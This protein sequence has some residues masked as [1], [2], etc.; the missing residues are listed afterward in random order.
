MQSFARLAAAEQDLAATEAQMPSEPGDAA[1]PAQHKLLAAQAQV[2]E[3]ANQ[4]KEASRQLQ[5]VLADK[6]RLEKQLVELQKQL[7]EQAAAHA[8][9]AGVELLC[10]RLMVSYGGGA[11]T[12][13]ETA[14]CASKAGDLSLHLIPRPI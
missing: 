11:L 5:V 9:Q 3:A 13:V 7:Q 12:P 4:A 6:E 14:G 1:L 2:V 10:G 8:G